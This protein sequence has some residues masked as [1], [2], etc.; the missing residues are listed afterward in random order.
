VRICGHLILKLGLTGGLAS[1]KSFIAAELERLGAIII[2]ADQLGHE[3]LLP[4]G[5]AYTPAVQHFGPAILTASGEIDRAILA[6]LV[7][8]N[9]DAL[10]ILNSFVH[11]AVHAREAE[12]FATAAPGSLVVVEA[13]ILI[14][15]GSYRNLDKLI[16]AHC[17]ESQQIE[18]A[19]GRS[20]A[21]LADI[22]A[23]L[24][25]QM[26]LSEKL[27]LADYVIDTSGTESAT[28]RQTRDLFD[29]LKKELSHRC[30]PAHSSSPLL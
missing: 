23:R 27:A 10:A 14:E 28:L 8:P 2:N 17:P 22:Q 11:P 3:A 6:K 1:G 29:T 26:S 7:F 9:P 15:S 30:D 18:R 5:S 12:L 19:L 13:A 25:R 20:G 24:S 21:T 16:V 4:T